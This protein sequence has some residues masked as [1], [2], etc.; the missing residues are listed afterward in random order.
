[1]KQTRVALPMGLVDCLEKKRRIKAKLK[2]TFVL[3]NDNLVY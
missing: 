3:Q 2:F 1:M